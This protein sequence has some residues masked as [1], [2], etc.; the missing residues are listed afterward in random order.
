MA[1]NFLDSTLSLLRQARANLRFGGVSMLWK[2]TTRYVGMR[3]FGKN[4]YFAPMTNCIV[5]MA[6]Q[7]QTFIDIGA[8]V[9]EVTVRVASSFP[10]CIAIEP[11]PEIVEELKAN[12]KK[13]KIVNCK[14]YACALGERAGVHELFINPHNTGDN[15]LV[16]DKGRVGGVNVQVDTLDNLVG[17]GGHEGPFVIKI[18]VQGYE[19]AIFR[20]GERTI[21]KTNAIISE[22]WPYGIHKAGY[23]PGAY[24]NF[25]VNHDFRVYQLN[26]EPFSPNMLLK[27]CNVGYLDP[28]VV[29][30]VLFLREFR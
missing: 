16:D 10:S 20:S 27:A 4:F 26:G 23:D 9:G 7:S 17:A 11:S 1:S 30:D 25:V 19:L 24:L 22:F 6:P 21:A 13:S 15:S 28:Y 18:D 12:I 2:Q 14:V 29:F 8:N 3:I 5:K